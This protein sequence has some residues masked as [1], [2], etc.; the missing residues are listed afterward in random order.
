MTSLVGARSTSLASEQIAWA[1][2]GPF[3]TMRMEAARAI[4]RLAVRL[5]D[6]QGAAAQAAEELAARAFCDV[7]EASWHNPLTLET[8][9]QLAHVA[10]RA[11][12]RALEDGTGWEVDRTVLQAVVAAAVEVVSRKEMIAELLRELGERR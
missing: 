9:R 4:A 5:A 1:L 11:Y 10:C 2:L 3:P 7:A 6:P 8:C 12:Q